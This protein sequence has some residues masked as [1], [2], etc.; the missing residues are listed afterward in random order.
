MY[1]RAAGWAALL[2]GLPALY[3]IFD[4]TASLAFHRS[5]DGAPR[6]DARLVADVMI[7]GRGPFHF[8][9]D[10]GASEAIITHA[11]VTRLGL[12]PDPGRWARVQGV[13]SHVVA[14]EVHVTSLQMGALRRQDIELPVLPGSLFNDLDGVIGAQDLHGLSVSIDLVDGHGIVATSIGS[15]HPVF[16]ADAVPLL[17]PSLPLVAAT[18]AG[19][20]ID[21]VIDT[22]SARTLGNTA[23]LR[24]LDQARA[25]ESL[26]A[27]AGIVDVTA[28]S[29]RVLAGTTPPLRLGATAVQPPSISFGDFEVFD[30]WGLATRPALLLGM[31][32]LDTLVH[33]TI[34]YA[35]LQLL[36]GE[37]L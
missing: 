30:Q 10:T 18:I 6:A 35:R 22:G 1:H 15:A 36:L 27:S 37:R 31:D 8:L 29:R 24:A 19:V 20:P 32:T 17:S 7:D 34:D 11:A 16:V 25:V 21:V 13:N 26:H 3:L 14:P 12:T 23:L 28:L 2:V 33:F 5:S 4:P 9:L